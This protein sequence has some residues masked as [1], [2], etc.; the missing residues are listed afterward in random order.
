M[1]RPKQEPDS[2]EHA[3]RSWSDA[4]Y[5]EHLVALLTRACAEL[6][7]L[8]PIRDPDLRAWYDAAPPETK[9][10]DPPK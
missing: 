5:A 4:E 9:E 7:D 3:I 6:D 2:E 10:P 8:G 1:I